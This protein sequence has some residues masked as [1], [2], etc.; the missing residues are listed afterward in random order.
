MTAI[1]TSTT[2]LVTI[3]LESRLYL[4]KSGAI[5]F[6]YAEKLRVGVL[7]WL[8]RE[9]KEVDVGTPEAY[10]AY[11]KALDLGRD[12]AEETG[13]KCP[14]ALTPELDRWRGW[15]VEV[16]SFDGTK[17]R[18]NV[19]RSTGWLPVNIE[20]YNVRSSGGVGTYLAPGDVVTP[21]RVAIRKKVR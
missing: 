11:V 2:T 7:T 18:F 1:V 10:E 14:A 21:I 4:H 16:K 6:D 15:R 17:R 5:G 9:I 20:L 13:A 12:H 19:S 3:Q 8:G